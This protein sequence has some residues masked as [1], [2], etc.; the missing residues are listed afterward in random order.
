MSNGQEEVNIARGS[1][2]GPDLSST[3]GCNTAFMRFL[4]VPSLQFSCFQDHWN[5]V[6]QVL[7]DDVPILFREHLKH[8][9]FAV[10]AKHSSTLTCIKIFCRDTFVFWQLGSVWCILL[11]CSVKFMLYVNK[12]TYPQCRTAKGFYY[13]HV[14]G[15]KSESMVMNESKQC[16]GFQEWRSC[17]LY[18]RVK[19]A[20]RVTKRTLFQAKISQSVHHIFINILS[21]RRRISSS[22]RKCDGSNASSNTRTIYRCCKN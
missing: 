6:F 3:D 12:S 15:G 13:N 5:L 11:L 1:K 4:F 7:W 17:G 10:L 2:Y 9:R 8:K 18:A 16:G 22:A 14:T 21:D 19:P 20:L